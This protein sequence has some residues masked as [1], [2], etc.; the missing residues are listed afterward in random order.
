MLPKRVIASN[1]YVNGFLESGDDPQDQ[2][3]Q[4]CIKQDGAS[5]AAAGN[6][7]ELDAIGSQ[8]IRL[9]VPVLVIEAF[10]LGPSAHQR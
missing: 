4:E 8:R 1:G 9:V 7:P 3:Q 6:P 2:K 10:V 5:G